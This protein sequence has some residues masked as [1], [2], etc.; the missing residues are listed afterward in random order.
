MTEAEYVK[1]ANPQKSNVFFDIAINGTPNG[2]I[3]FRLFD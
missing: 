1:R 3:V 2:R